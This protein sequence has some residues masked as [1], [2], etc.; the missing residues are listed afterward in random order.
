MRKRSLKKRAEEHV[1]V[2]EIGVSEVALGGVD[3]GS[4]Q[5]RRVC[6]GVG[7]WRDREAVSAV[8]R[9]WVGI[10]EDRRRRKYP[11]GGSTG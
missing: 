8:V 11:D 10:Q 9:F 7:V 4:G 3:V 1:R 5:G 2:G 6:E